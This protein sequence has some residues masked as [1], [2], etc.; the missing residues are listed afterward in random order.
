MLRVPKRKVHAPISLLFHISEE[1]RY[2]DRGRAV[3]IG[4]PR[5]L[6]KV[7]VGVPCSIIWIAFFQERI[8][9]A[10]ES[11]GMKRVIFHQRVCGFSA[12]LSGEPSSLW[13]HKLVNW[14]VKMKLFLGAFAVLRKATISFVRSVGPLG[15]TRFPLDGFSWNL[16][17][18]D[19]SK[20]V[21]KIQAS[22]NS[23]RN[24][25]YCTWRPLYVYGS[26]SLSSS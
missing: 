1:R 5:M 16:I 22:L 14:N 23:G 2:V 8:C 11:G 7:P 6:A 26:I 17:F 18:E 15:T 10:T 20:S 21:E 24:I 19:F 25:A 4:F 3:G 13:S 9:G 12:R